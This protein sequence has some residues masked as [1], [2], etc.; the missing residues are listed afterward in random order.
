MRP[1]KFV[2]LPKY[3]LFG[4]VLNRSPIRVFSDLKRGYRSSIW[5][6]IRISQIGWMGGGIPPFGGDRRPSLKER[7]AVY[8]KGSYGRGRRK[9]KDHFKVRK[10]SSRRI[11]SGPL[12]RS[13]AG[14]AK[15][16]VGFCATHLPGLSFLGSLPS[17]GPTRR[18]SD[19]LRSTG[20]GWNRWTRED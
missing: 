9:Q 19:S 7:P 5:A 10:D 20:R 3:G 17:E 15:H 11:F 16:L 13:D 14:R 12:N 8:E 4:L 1:I 2:R 6:R 18:P